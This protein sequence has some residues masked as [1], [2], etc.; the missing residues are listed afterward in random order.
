M[1]LWL[2]VGEC[3]LVRTLGLSC[4]FECSFSYGTYFVQFGRLSCALT[5]IS[6]CVT[7]WVPTRLSARYLIVL[8][9]YISLLLAYL[10][11]CLFD[12]HTGRPDIQSDLLSDSR[13]SLTVSH[14]IQPIQP[15]QPIR[16][17]QAQVEC[18]TD[19]TGMF[20]SRS[21]GSPDKLLSP[22]Q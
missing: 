3:A 17:D 14:Q 13:A 19:S 9:C 16:R 18:S 5:L 1:R 7:L 10:C 2:C 20:R 15:I 4:L 6:Y 11:I 12:S 21:E 8:L 22:R